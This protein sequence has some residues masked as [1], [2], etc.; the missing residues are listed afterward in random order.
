MTSPRSFDDPAQGIHFPGAGNRFAQRWPSIYLS[1][2]FAR[3]QAGP[4]LSLPPP[5]I[6]PAR[7]IQRPHARLPWAAVWPFTSLAL[8][9]HIPGRSLA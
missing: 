3:P 6:Y 7:V 9:C 1:A 8:A 4:A 2:V 5:L